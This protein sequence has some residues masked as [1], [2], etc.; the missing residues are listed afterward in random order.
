MIQRFVSYNTDGLYD[1]IQSMKGITKS[2]ES[3]G[4]GEEIELT[5]TKR[6]NI[7]AIARRKGITVS[8]TKTYSGFAVTRTGTLG[9]QAVQPVQIV[10]ERQ[11]ERQAKLANLRA[12]IAPIEAGQSKPEPADQ[13]TGWTAEQ[14]TYDDQT[15]EMRT[16]RKHIKSGRVKWLQAETYLG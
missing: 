1:I 2:I 5:G 3:L 13:W 9:E 12:L 8:V 11:D 10:D 15:G 7:Y 6:E 4:I 14:Q 16:F